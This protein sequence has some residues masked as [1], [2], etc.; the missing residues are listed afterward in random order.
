[1]SDQEIGGGVEES[2]P[3]YR[4]IVQKSTDLICRFSADGTLTFVNETFC[5][6]F[7]RSNH[8]LLGQSLPKLISGEPSVPVDGLL[9]KLVD[10]VPPLTQSYRVRVASDELRWLQWTFTVAREE[11][12]NRLEYQATG[13]DVTER[14]RAERGLR[15]ILEVIAPLTGDDFFRALVDYLVSA[16]QVQIAVAGAIDPLDP[17]RINTIAISH[18]GVPQENFSYELKGTPC[19]D[20]LSQQQ[21]CYHELNVQKRFPN[22]ELLID[23]GIQSYMGVPLQKSGDSLGLIVLLSDQAIPDPEQA[24]A[25]LTVMASRATAELERQKTHRALSIFRSL[26]DQSADAFEV[27][28]AKT[29]QFLDINQKACEAHGYTR[30][31]F[32]A[33]TVADIDPIIRR[34][35]WQEHFTRLRQEGSVTFESQHQRKDGSIFPVDVSATYVALDRE[36]FL[37]VVRD[38]SE[39]KRA[40]EIIRKSEERL[41]KIA[42]TMPQALYLFDV[43]EQK[44]VYSNREVWEI[45]GYTSE[46]AHEM[47]PHMLDRLLHP[48]DLKRL[49]KLLSRW[50]TAQDADVLYVEYRMRDAAG[51]WRWFSSRD[52]VFQ[53]DDDGRVRQIIGTTNDITDRKHAEEQRRIMDAQIMHDQKLE[54][55]EEL[56]GGI[57]HDF[58]NLLTVI[59]S[60]AGLAQTQITHGSPVLDMLKEI[61]HASE[62]AGD[63]TRQLLAY[64]GQGSFIIEPMRLD[65]LVDE[66]ASLLRTAIPEGATVTSDLQPATIE[67][68]STQI[69]QIIMN[70][71]KNAAD[72]L[73]PGEGKI[74]LAT[75]VRMVDGRELSSQFVPEKLSKGQYAFVRVDDQGCGMDEETLSKMFD[76][77]F[78]TKPTGKGLGLAAVLGIVRGHKGTINAIST[79]GQG[80]TVDIL[81]PCAP[82]LD[83]PRPAQESLL[84]QGQGTILVIDDEQELRALAR[85]ILENAGY[86]VHTVSSGAEGIQYAKENQDQTSAVLL[87]LKMPRMG[88]EDV[89]AKIRAFS[90]T[91]VIL[92]SGCGEQEITAALNG[93][94]VDCMLS[95]P[96]KSKD[97]LMC[98]DRVLP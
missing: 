19:E 87:D 98:L 44:N 96:F 65:L 8:E 13:R 14:E 83:A 66:M 52:T 91:P 93:Q 12:G 73:P 36:Y 40:A 69:R 84:A 30:E 7:R 62:R 11:G 35:N 74:S 29:G 4:D 78:S 45:L 33:L 82:M 23:M 26:I 46:Q 89:L 97:L 16:C 47:G 18:N 34:N 42:S 9:R 80:S 61:E 27:I 28:D 55:L 24:N 6:F 81:I 86:S 85:K 56:A 31:E 71:V 67:G 77:F 60:Y 79:P 20:M 43:I 95:K 21:H 58:N 39:R 17:G 68:D 50:E 2:E 22:D 38:I 88:G 92:M 90:D 94:V 57:A 25:L 10:S 70:L 72:S 51:N 5:R 49:P 59:M 41:T 37:A 1:M 3:P 53:R 15:H 64:A 63:L 48:D 75:G 54:S 76:P 32:L